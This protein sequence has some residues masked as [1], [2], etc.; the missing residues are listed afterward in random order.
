MLRFKSS[1]MLMTFSRDG[2]RPEPPSPLSRPVSLAL[3]FPIRF[4]RQLFGVQGVFRMWTWW[5]K[6]ARE[7]RATK[8]LSVFPD[9]APAVQAV[10]ATLHLFPSS[11]ARHAAE[12]LRGREISDEE[13]HRIGNRW[14]RAWA[15]IALSR[16]VVGKTAQSIRPGGS[17]GRRLEL[18]ADTGFAAPNHTT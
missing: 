4:G 17:A 18:H 5:A 16:G 10:L 11:Q 8:Y 14:E 13:W 1:M 2:L 12:I 9:D 6:K 3:T 7:R 15:A